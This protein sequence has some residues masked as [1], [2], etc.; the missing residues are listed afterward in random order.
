MEKLPDNIQRIDLLRIVR[1]MN[2]LCKCEYPAYTVDTQNRLVYCQTCEA[3]IDPYEA[4]TKMARRYEKISDQV[5]NL[6]ESA[7]QIQNYKPHLKV[8]KDIE[9][10]YQSNHFS[11]LPRC[12]SCGDPFDFKDI[13]EWVGRNYAHLYRKDRPKEGK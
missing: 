6:L 1:N 7:K 10:H 9:S 8:F 11:M 5:E 13:N 2:K 12:P 4:L 3:I